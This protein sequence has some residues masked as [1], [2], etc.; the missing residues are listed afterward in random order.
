MLKKL[1]ALCLVFLGS[2]TP[3]Y[4]AS[5]YIAPSIAYQGISTG[6]VDYMGM[7]AQLAVGF[8][9]N[10]NGTP[11]YLAG[12][13]F[14]SPKPATLHN[15]KGDTL[16][17]K[18]SYT[19]GISFI[20]GLCLDDTILAYVRLGMV[21]TKFDTLNLSRTGAQ[22]GIGVLTNIATHWDLRG[23]YDYTSYRSISGVG[24]PKADE[25]LLGLLYRFG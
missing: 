24:S 3:T 20:P 9:G 2:L 18:P 5:V 10:V 12:E 21:N 22:V 1:S 11:V 25:Y 15:N 19:V 13:I 7:I 4:A 14:G 17:L 23:E 16:G 6:D 8:G